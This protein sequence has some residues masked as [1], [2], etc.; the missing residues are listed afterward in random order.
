[1]SPTTLGGSKKGRGMTDSASRRLLLTNQRFDADAALAAILLIVNRCSSTTKHRTFKLLYLAEKLHLERY[2]YLIVGDDYYA[3]T[4]GPVPSRI[5]YAI[6]FAAGHCLCLSLDEDLKEGFGSCLKVHGHHLT[7]RCEPDLGSLS[8]SDV[9][10]IL[11]TI[12]DHG[13]KSLGRLAKLSHDQAWYRARNGGDPSCLMDFGEIVG[14]LPN[15]EEIFEHLSNPYLV[16]HGD[17]W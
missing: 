11:E 9:S 15:A 8:E 3:M 1:M 6:K 12:N 5:Y 4:Y 2:G 10:C 7:A 16:V 13:E 17:S 14:T